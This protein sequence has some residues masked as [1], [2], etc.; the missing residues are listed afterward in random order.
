MTT[1]LRGFYPEIEPYETGMLDVGDG[2]QRV[3]ARGRVVDRDIPAVGRKRERDLPPDAA[4]GAR[5][6]G[7]AVPRSASCDHGDGS[8][9]A[10]AGVPE[11]SSALRISWTGAAPSTSSSR[12]C[13]RMPKPTF[14][15]CRWPW[16]AGSWVRPL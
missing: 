16:L 8:V 2:P 12:S 4:R 15:P 1:E 13:T 11:R 5:D 3:L 7:G 9:P 14:S 10:R 6:E